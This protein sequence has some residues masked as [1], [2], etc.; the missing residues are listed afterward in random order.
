MTRGVGPMQRSGQQR[1]QVDRFLDQEPRERYGKRHPAMESFAGRV[2]K[3]WKAE[4]LEGADCSDEPNPR[5]IVQEQARIAYDKYGLVYDDVKETW[6]RPDG[7]SQ[8]EGG[9][10]EERPRRTEQWFRNFYNSSPNR[11]PGRM[12]KFDLLLM[13][14]I[15]KFPLKSW[16][17]AKEEEYF[18]DRHIQAA[19][20]GI[21]LLACG[22]DFIITN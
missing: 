1:S 14:K 8:P 11:P 21:N 3:A 6:I 5:R 9:K 4:L 12:K 15:L 19:K 2:R 20:I 22:L 10:G 13:G 17:L 16:V 7:K 18:F